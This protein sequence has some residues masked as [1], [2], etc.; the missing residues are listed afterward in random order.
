MCKKSSLKI[1]CDCLPVPTLYECS[2]ALAATLYAAL[3]VYK[4]IKSSTVCATWKGFI[5]FPI[6][7]ENT[8]SFLALQLRGLQSCG[9]QVTLITGVYEFGWVSSPNWQPSLWKRQRWP[10][11]PCL[12]LSDSMTETTFF[13]LLFVC[14]HSKLNS[15][16]MVTHE[17]FNKEIRR[18]AGWHSCQ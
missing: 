10:S 1:F 13:S 8:G 4:L 11:Q 9:T 14:G 2:Q 12:I 6:M 3:L 7:H 18:W 5:T 16:E 17:A 15:T